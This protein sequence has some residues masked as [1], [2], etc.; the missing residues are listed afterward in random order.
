[1]CCRHFNL[2]GQRYKKKACTASVQAIFFRITDKII[3]VKD[4]IEKFSPPFLSAET[5]LSGG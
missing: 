3:K 1:M 4:K 5:T 2:T